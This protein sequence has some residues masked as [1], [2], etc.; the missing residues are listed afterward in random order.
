M[1]GDG[2][3]TAAAE[4]FPASAFP[5]ANVAT[6]PQRS[7]LRYPGG[8]TWL[9]PHIRHWLKSTNPEILIEPFAGGA[10]VSLTAVM[11]NLVG[12]AVMV[13]IDRDVAAFWR[14]ALESGEALRERVAEF[15]PTLERLQKLERDAPSTVLEHGFRTLVLNRT[16]RNGILAPGASFCRNGEGG[17]G[18]LSRWYPGTLA[19]RLAA[20]QEHS[21]RFLFLEGDGLRLLP[22]ILEGWGGR[23]AV[24]ID[25]P[26]TARGGKNAGSRLYDHSSIDHA[27]LFSIL[28]EHGANFLMTYDPAGEI[29]ELVRTHEFSAVGLLMKN[30][31]HD[32]MREIVITSEPL[33]A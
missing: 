24:F 9:V 18:L 14:C 16:R 23:A 13:E 1:P 8:K 27:A 21:E 17:K 5:V 31:H 29:V 30:G 28:A 12:S 2:H 20:I 19:A 33:F 26:Y 22:V 32:R 10:I 3:M 7:P 11:E 6:V 4:L 15:K 25:P